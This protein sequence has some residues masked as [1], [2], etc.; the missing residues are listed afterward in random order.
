MA[1][2]PLAIE[3][4][5]G[6][7]AL[8]REARK[9]LEELAQRMDDDTGLRIRIVAV[10]SPV[11][12]AARRLALKRARIAWEYLT[13]RGVAGHRITVRTE[14]LHPSQGRGDRLDVF[15]EGQ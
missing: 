11:E 2:D 15:V 5:S 3:F 1:N 9:S 6:T 10:A 7:A 13:G 8:H 14:S 4:S 12:A